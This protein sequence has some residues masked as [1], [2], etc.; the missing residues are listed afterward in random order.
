MRQAGFEYF[1]TAKL[2]WN[3]T[4][5]PQDL[6]FLWTG[7]DGSSIRTHLIDGYGGNPDPGRLNAVCRD[8]RR[9]SMPNG[10]CHIYQYGAGDGGGGISE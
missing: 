3:D 1:V 7:I 4:N 5:K 2:S 9:A 10:D 8:S 6:S